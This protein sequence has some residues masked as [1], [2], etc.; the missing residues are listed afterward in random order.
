MMFEAGIVVAIV[1]ALGE[2][3]KKYLDSKYVPIFTLIVGIAGG[4][5]YLPHET[6]KEAVMNGVMV[7]LAANGLFDITKVFKPEQL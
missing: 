2:F 6:V 4:F 5:F 7:S 1:L 3:A